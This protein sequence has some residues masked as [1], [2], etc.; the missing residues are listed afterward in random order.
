VGNG[1]HRR[2]KHTHHDALIDGVSGAKEL[3]NGAIFTR[4]WETESEGTRGYL[5]A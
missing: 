3:A 2:L 5:H 1:K 4:V